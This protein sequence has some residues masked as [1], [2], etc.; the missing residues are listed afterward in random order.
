AP[1]VCIVREAD[2][3][4]EC[5]HPAAMPAISVV[6]IVDKIQFITDETD[7]HQS[8]AKVEA[9]LVTIRCDSAAARSRSARACLRIEIRRSCKATRPVFEVANLL[10]RSS[11]SIGGNLLRA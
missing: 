11:F 4:C 8:H 5:R 3:V 2:V 7:H 1:S 10:T 6:L 9:V